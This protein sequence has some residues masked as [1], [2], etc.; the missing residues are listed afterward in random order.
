[1]IKLINTNLISF[2][3]DKSLSTIWEALQLSPDETKERKKHLKAL[4]I[5]TYTE[6]VKNEY[7]EYDKFNH[8]LI[9]AKSDFR[10][11]KEMLGDFKTFI[12]P[13]IEKLPI[14]EQI[15]AINQI[16]SKLLEE[17]KDQIE[18]SKTQFRYLQ[19]LYNELEIPQNRRGEFQKDEKTEYTVSRLNRMNNKIGELQQEKTRRI[20]L[21]NHLSK[22]IHSIAKKTE[23]LVD[24]DIKEISQ[25]KKVSSAALNRLEE[26]NST[27]IDLDHS[28][29]DKVR[30]LIHQIKELYSL[31]AIDQRDW[32]QF[33]YT[34]TLSN[35]SLLEKELEFLE[36][37]KDERL[38]SVIDFSRKEINRLSEM[39]QIPT[40]Q[41]PKYY[42]NDKM[43]EARYYQNA[44][45]KLE[46][47][48]NQ[49]GLIQSNFGPNG[50]PDKN[51][52]IKTQPNSKYSNHSAQTDKN[53]NYF[54]N[55]A[56]TEKRLK[57]PNL[58]EISPKPERNSPYLENT[59]ESNK[60]GRILDNT[61]Q[62]EVRSRYLDNSP[63]TE[64]L[65]SYLNDT[66]NLGKKSRYLADSPKTEIN[67]S[68]INESLEAS[69]NSFHLVNSSELDNNSSRFSNNS[70]KS[71]SKFS[72]NSS[73]GDYSLTS[74]LFATPPK[75]KTL[76]N[77]FDESEDEN[78]NKT[79]FENSNNNNKNVSN[80]YEY[81]NNKNNSYNSFPNDSSKTPSPKSPKRE[82]T[83]ML[84]RSR[85]PFHT[86]V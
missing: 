36:A 68:N 39:L 10:K 25:K 52:M 49:S 2:E 62:T 32:I 53:K 9:K 14:K 19:K 17:H 24:D 58:N 82:I 74:A 47:Q 16:T 55:S 41:R 67:P 85:D 70:P 83:E 3:I 27:L 35:I 75:K 64:I 54:D 6:F 31:L 78:E 45:S 73:M 46:V 26:T 13:N 34:P 63:Q 81:E 42:G 38:P 40:N 79:N 15:V 61:P 72:K 1:M 20:E 69:K 43:E 23:E 76:V 44:I 60:S 37:Q 33:S 48:V 11:T 4:L 86:Y 65:S 18:Q 77:V 59:P 80:E 51:Y 22:S 7:L 28:R 56:Q 5:E 66:P 71:K 84:L 8:N 29:M 30:Y 21:N 50:S 57:R 12:A